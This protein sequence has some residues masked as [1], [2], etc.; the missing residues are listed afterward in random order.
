MN[1]ERLTPDQRHESGRALRRH[2]SRESHGEWLAAPDRRDP[3]EL[4]EGQ[5][6][7]RIDWLVPVRRARMSASPFTF[8]RGAARIMAHD[9]AATP[10]SG[11][12]TQ[13]CGDAHLANFGNYASPE[14][15]LVNGAEWKTWRNCR[16]TVRQPRKKYQ[17][18][19]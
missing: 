17:Y 12:Q 4:L 2:A 13:I 19:R 8:Y 7:D 10:V 6:T 9:L 16:Y 1:D 3:V 18:C 14:R 15:R 5:N 11:L